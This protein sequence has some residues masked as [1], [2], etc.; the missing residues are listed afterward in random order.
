MKMPFSEWK[1]KKTNYWGK[2]GNLKHRLKI[3]EPIKQPEYITS[4]KKDI[5]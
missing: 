3:I 1:A 2:I 4:P 5:K